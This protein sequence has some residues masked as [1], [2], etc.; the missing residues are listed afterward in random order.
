VVVSAIG[1]FNE[2]QWPDIPGLDEFRGTLFHS[3]RWNHAH[4]LSGKS[5]A[6][7]G[8]AATAV[9]MIPEI[10]KAVGRLYVYQ[11][12]ANW[13]LPK[14][15]G[16]FTRE[17][18]ARFVNEPDA[19]RSEREKIYGEVEKNCTFSDPQVRRDAERAG[20]AALSAVTDPEVRRKLTPTVAWGCH[21]PL[22]TNDYYPTFNRPNVELVT[23]SIEKISGD[24]ILTADGK[25]R[26]I[27][28][29]VLATGFQVAR[30]LSAIDVT[31]RGDRRLEDEWRD[32]A[33]AYLGISV[34]GF[35]NLFMLYGP[36]TNNGSILQMLEY[37]VEFVLRQI[38]LMETGKI[39]WMDV[40][41]EAMER[42][43]A[44][45]QEE[46]AVIEVWQA[47]CHNYY[48]AESGRIVTQWP[49]T[50]SEYRR[51]CRASPPDSY[52]ISY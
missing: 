45:I 15:N 49:N 7:I 36:N 39:T 50:M 24:S 29:L 25:E 37:Q 23:E 16:P 4:D 10:A 20:L 40:R 13:V 32:G 30:F 5:V 46:L 27:D 34:P 22:V 38:Q 12:S 11:R 14:A 28:T 43:D 26:R 48:R 31:G 9:Q 19:A 33:R 6:V 35:P 51:R 3:A 18:S 42:Y 44:Q 2:L 41:R 8:S 21:R 1:M 52:E 17:Q 47:V